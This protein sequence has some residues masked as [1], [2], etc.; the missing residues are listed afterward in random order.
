MK[1]PTTFGAGLAVLFLLST[2]LLAEQ[3][4]FSE[5]HY[6]PKDGKPEYIE[7]R[8][9]TATPFDIANWRISG[10]VDFEFPDFTLQNPAD[11]YLSEFEYIVVSAVDEATLRASYT[12]IPAETKVFSSWTGA[13][14]NAGEHLVL[15]DKNGTLRAEVTYNDDGRKWSIAADGA[16]HSVHLAK[17]NRGGSNWRNWEASRDPD[18]T[19]GEPASTGQALSALLDL[20]EIHFAPN[21]ELDWVELHAP[22]D[23]AVPVDTYFIASLKDF[24]DAIPLSGSITAGGYA[25][26]STT[27]TTDLAGD[28]EL[29]VVDTGGTVIAAQKFTR[30]LGQEGFQSLPVGEE[31][32]GGPGH[33]RDAANN[34]TDRNTDLVIN[35]IMYDSPSDART[36]EFIE[37]YNRG[38]SQLDLSGWSFVDGISFTFPTGTTLNPGAYLV[39]AADA[40]WLSTQ[41]G[42]IQILG[43]FT[44]Q[45]S[46]SGE[47]LRLEDAAGNL[48]DE[49]DYLPSGDWPELADGDGSSMELKHPSMNNDSP[50]AW[51]DSDETNKSTMQD[52]TYTANFDQVI[53]NPITSGQEIHLHLV[54][55][56]H[57][58]LDSIS[59][60]LNGD[61]TNLLVQPTTMSQTN[62][63]SGGW[64][65]QGTHWATHIDTS[66]AP[67]QL[68]LI[69]DGHGDNKANRVEQD[70]GNLT[71]N[72]SYTFSFRGRWISGKPRLIVQTL[73]HGFGTSFRFPIPNNLGTPGIAN[74][75]LIATAAP[76]V[77]K[78]LHSPAVPSTTDAVTITARVES[79][80]TLTSVE[81]VHR[82]D[83]STGN[84]TWF[85]STMY[86]DG[87]SGGDEHAGDGL[88]TAA[89]IQYSSQE[90]IVQFYVEALAD[91]GETTQLP[92]L[93]P[94]RPAMW[95]VDDRAMP[96]TLMQERFIVSQYD[97]DAMIASLGDSSLYG[98]HFP[99]M[100]NH[101]F[102]ATFISNES[103]VFYNAEIRKS[104]SGRI[105]DFGNSL[106]HGKWKLP[107]D[108]LFR[109]RRRTA[110]DPSGDSITLR[111]YDDRLA[112]YFLYLLGHPTNENEF[113]HWVVNGDSFK[114]RENQEPISNDFLKRNWDDGT[115]GTLL[116]I[117]YQ[118]RFTNDN[119]IDRIHRDAD[120]SYKNSDNPVRYHS[121]WLMRTRETEHDYSNFVEFVR[122]LDSN[123]FDEATINRLADRDM[124]CLNAAVRGYNGDFDSLTLRAGKNSYFYR[125]K[126]GRWMLIHW[127]GDRVFNNTN[128]P[129]LGNLP[130]IP[131]YFDKPFNRRV[132]NYYLTE[133][134][135]KYTEGSPRTNAWMDAETLAVAGS[136]ITMTKSHYENWFTN[137]KNTAHA[138]I[139]SAL[140]TTF[141]ITTSNATTSADTI[142]LTGTS[143]STVYEV[144]VDGQP[145]VIPSWSS[146][147][148]WTLPDVIL[149]TGSN[150]ITVEGINHDGTVVTSQTFLITKTGN[151]PPVMTLEG[152]PLS[153][154]VGLAEGLGLDATA[155]YDPDGGA[156][157]FG[158]APSPTASFNSTDGLA[159]AGFTDPGLYEFTVTGTDPATGSTDLTREAAVYGGNGFSNF[160]SPLLDPFWETSNLQVVNNLGS[161]PW[162]S[163]EYQPGNLLLS[164]PGHQS[165][166]LGGAVD[167][168]SLTHPWLKR[169]L[170]S[171]GDWVL[172]TDLTLSG[173]Q[174]GDFMTGL[175]VE[176]AD[177]ADRNRYAFGY[178]D[179]NQLAV[180]QLTP[181]TSTVEL[182]SLPYGLSSDMDLR[183]RR[184]GN[185]L[186][187][188]WRPNDLFEEV[189][190]LALPA[191]NLLFDGGPF[192][193]TEAEEIVN[194]T[195]DYVMLIDPTP[196]TP[197]SDAL[198]ISEI[199]Y[200]PIGGDLYEFLEL[201]NTGSTTIDLTG[202]RF[203]QGDPFDEFVF[204]AI[205]IG[206]GEYRL[207]VHNLAAFRSRYGEGRNSI[208]AGEWIGGNLSNF[209]ETI[210]LLDAQGNTV[211]S[212]TYFDSSPWPTAPDND[213]SSLVLI[214][215]V[216]GEMSNGSDW[217]S[218]ALPGGTP[219]SS[220]LSVAFAAWLA[221]RGETDPLATKE[222]EPVNNLL[223]YAFGLDLAG[224]DPFVALPRSGEMTIVDDTFLTFEYRRRLSDPGIGYTV[225]TSHDASTWSDGTPDIVAVN[226][227]NE[228]DGTERVTVRLNNP[229]GAED[230][231]LIRIL[232]T[233]P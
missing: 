24:S 92:K 233:A 23:A 122:T 120:W 151:A 218:S 113:V 85:R 203:P 42:S 88:Y 47:L 91:G 130:G 217:T 190:R 83:T 173:L 123:T 183:I 87:I 107:G 53:W 201:H 224:G 158:W 73:D 168:D 102:N 214:D 144:R 196:I 148:N 206:P 31:W 129:I 177:P 77:S 178:Q 133:L 227:I 165:Y 141:A 15:E 167:L 221:A 174:F 147:T 26:W 229:L 205:T 187:F 96:D 12:T 41:H 146:T 65:E 209:S 95:I 131:T 104:G 226:I 55:D 154:N 139:G 6:N 134:L 64:V 220:E 189:H 207:V 128:E 70:I 198:V 126:G 118:W 225:Q 28:V 46:D 45:L 56:S 74:S 164:I 135:D 140:N 19:P 219:G 197:P 93:G 61:G 191:G 216:N 16:G 7:I 35:E 52:F 208:I 9:L 14:N 44:G 108:R 66:T 98:Y 152:D 136:G 80:A 17:A 63:S 155:S 86:D 176:V 180:V 162:Y 223:A 60:E 125:P 39:V 222:G 127:D 78:V 200:K 68:N 179:G 169:E 150:T 188:E 72:A 115:D 172:Q 90:N 149:Y 94:D 193:S 185:D 175:L 105:R 25:S 27:F 160:S 2:P 186:I 4:V 213:G 132:L 204:G 89:I 138:F 5:I 195:F 106:V 69:S 29:Y 181:T 22:G 163:L 34:P 212:F 145:S 67:P 37:L 40:S 59:M 231:L 100:S 121:E 10:G 1:K 33:T 119:G 81:V 13:L 157:S 171:T 153:F 101:F 215:P 3:V 184:E 156:L 211:L 18:G 202:F 142:S 62:D 111:Y 114:L 51:A 117:D 82:L 71:Y 32:F 50:S 48:V 194:V 84:G 99:R 38:T 143:P 112:R 230:I 8:N 21:G 49:V 137:R 97:R 20:S 161:G 159:S 43:D 54:G 170:P 228:G 57:L 232:V 124:L 36:G 110:F 58:V 79:S 76:T 103:E 109:E 116:R 30:D 192:S 182:F 75:Q 199:L 210:T 11:T 166:P